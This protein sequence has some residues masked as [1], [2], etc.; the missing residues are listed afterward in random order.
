ML[1]WTRPGYS[2]RRPPQARPRGLGGG[3]GLRDS[4]GQHVGGTLAVIT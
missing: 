1:E 3:E 2:P 4:S